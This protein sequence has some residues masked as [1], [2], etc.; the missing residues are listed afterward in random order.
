MMKNQVPINP[1]Y[2][3]IFNRKFNIVVILFCCILNL[4]ST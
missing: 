3:G 4:L 2:I 1:Y